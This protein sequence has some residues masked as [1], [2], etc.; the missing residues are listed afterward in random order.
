MKIMYKSFDHLER[1]PLQSE[2]CDARDNSWGY[3]M[4]CGWKEGLGWGE[5]V[6]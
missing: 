5:E 3:D 2:N 6:L 4:S 1:E